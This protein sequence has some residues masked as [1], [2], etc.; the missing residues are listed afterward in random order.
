MSYDGTPDETSLG[1]LEQSKR[2]G[3]LVARNWIYTVRVPNGTN[4]VVPKRVANDALTTLV[5]VGALAGI[6]TAIPTIKAKFWGIEKNVATTVA[7]G[8]NLT[9]LTGATSD[10][11]TASCFRTDASKTA[12]IGIIGACGTQKPCLNRSA[13]VRALK[14]TGAVPHCGLKPRYPNWGI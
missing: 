10:T 8:G 14:T 1:D 3:D 4:G 13:L 7:Y 9:E 11:V 5:F 6:L 2:T 12:W